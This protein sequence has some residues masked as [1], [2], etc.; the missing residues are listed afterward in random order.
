M[1][2]GNSPDL[3]KIKNQGCFFSAKSC[4][5]RY[6]LAFNDIHGQ[7]EFVEGILLETEV[8]QLDIT[9]VVNMIMIH[10]QKFETSLVPHVF[11]RMV[12]KNSLGPGNVANVGCKKK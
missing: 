10:N 3:R 12:A 4:S 8:G 6:T 2:C 1:V 5:V 9:Y 11:T 7:A